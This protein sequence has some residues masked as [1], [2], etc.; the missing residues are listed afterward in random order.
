MISSLAVALPH[1]CWLIAYPLAGWAGA[2][3]GF[4]IAAAA[5]LAATRPWPAHDPEEIEHIYDDLAEDHPHIAGA[6]RIDNGH[7]HAHVFVIDSHHPEWPAE[8]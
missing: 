1:V 3:A 7:K 8:R 5:M 6:A 2:T 4:P